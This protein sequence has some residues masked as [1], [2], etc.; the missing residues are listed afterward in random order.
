MSVSCETNVSVVVEGPPLS[1]EG[2]SN[3]FFIGV[4]NLRINFPLWKHLSSSVKAVEVH[5][6]FR[7]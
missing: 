2:F 1:G 6:Y 7:R 5:S 4:N 3:N